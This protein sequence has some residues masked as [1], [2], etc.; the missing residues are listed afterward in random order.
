MTSARCHILTEMC[1]DRTDQDRNVPWPKGLTQKWLR[2]KSPVP[3][4]MKCY[5]KKSLTKNDTKNVMST[6]N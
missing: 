1:R 6:V 4:L 3:L 5:F 2:P